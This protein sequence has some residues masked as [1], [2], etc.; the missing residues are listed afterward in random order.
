MH[1][2]RGRSPPY[3]LDSRGRLVLPEAQVGDEQNYV[4][5]VRVGAASTEA[6][7]ELRMFGECLRAPRKGRAGESPG[8]GLLTVMSPPQRN[9]R[10]R[11]SSPTKGSCPWWMTL[12]RRYLG[13]DLDSRVL[14]DTGAGRFALL[15]HGGGRGWGAQ[16]PISERGEVP[17][18][19]G[20]RLRSPG[21]EPRAMPVSISDR[22]LP[23]PQ[24][25][26]RPPDHV[27][28]ERAAAQGAHGGEHR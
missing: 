25:E 24:R 9:R 13:P 15:R 12:P 28:P 23:Q 11:R 19:E 5:V 2:S 14:G 18:K 4:C 26:P 21:S 3:Q 1:D 6:T 17:R 10:P 16:A 7:T 20:P 8:K 27:V 22:H